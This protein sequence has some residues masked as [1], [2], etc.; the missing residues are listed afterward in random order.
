M[1]VQFANPSL[2]WLLSLIAIP[3]IIHLFNFRRFKKID[4]TNVKYLKE[5]K[6]QT[7][8][9]S[10]LKH[11]L[12]LISRILAI[13]FLVLAFSQPFIPK[14]KSAASGGQAVVS[15]FIDNSFSM[16]GLSSEGNLLD[17]AKTKAREVA[18]AFPASAQFQLLTNNFAG[19]QQRL[20]G[21]EELLDNIDK[22]RVS[23]VSKTAKEV[24]TRQRDALNSNSSL[25]KTAFWFSDFQKN[26]LSDV[27]P[28]D[29]TIKLNAALLNASETGNIYID[30]CWLSSPVI[31][32]NTPVEL[33]IKIKN[34]GNK[35]DVDVPLKF[36]INDAQ[37]AA[38]TLRVTA[39][40][41][42]IAKINF[43]VS[44]SGWQNAMV[45][46]DDNP[47]TFDDSYYFS[48]KLADK[49]NLY[50]I[51]RG[52]NIFIKKLLTENP[53][54]SYTYSGESGVDFSN[55][56]KSNA[57]ILSDLKEV[58]TGM[59][60]ELAKFVSR[61]GTLIVFPDTLINPSGY[62][63]LT[64]KTQTDN[65]ISLIG[66]KD[67]IGKIDFDNDLFSNMFDKIQENMNLPDIIS[68]YSLTSTVRS[69]RE[70]LLRLQS[71][72]PF[73]NRYKNGKGYVY[74]F[75][76]A[77]QPSSSAFVTHALF[78]PV[79]FKAVLQSIPSLQSSF[80]IGSKD[81]VSFPYP[82]STE[83]VLHL[84]NTKLNTDLIP[85]ARSSQG[86]T[87]LFIPDLT[88]AG[89]YRLTNKKDSL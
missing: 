48:F 11:L 30:S 76:A 56:T 71:G 75:A 10:R 87:S 24:F 25:N 62:L 77:A 44:Q 47:I 13:A 45:T 54:I 72:D 73:L 8:S 67:K 20:M 26:F 46:V 6:D 66:S 40:S 31:Q 23:P 33:S 64:A 89:F 3:V 43:T 82:L 42:A 37:K 16:K 68:H 84:V 2:L 83:E 9:Q 65:F 19:E 74:I 29:T 1:P 32:R 55:L 17:E 61:G 36:T 81:F 80:T 53:L 7:Q 57:V 79:L 28:A 51:G 21:K 86:E 15:L 63:A 50:H 88:D 27:L 52:Q 58:P 69:N 49:I 12:V 60:D 38:T 78:V 4:F 35:D 18:N 14:N 39:N 85:E 22:I 70:V 41:E 34:T 59:S 5:L